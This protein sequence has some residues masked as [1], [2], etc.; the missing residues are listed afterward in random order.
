MKE[1]IIDHPLRNIRLRYNTEVPKS[2]AELQVLHD[3]VALHDQVWRQQ[4]W[5]KSFKKGLYKIAMRQQYQAYQVNRLFKDLAQIYQFL[6]QEIQLHQHECVL[7]LRCRLE[8]FLLELQAI[9]KE[10]NDLFDDISAR[11]KQ[12]EDFWKADL[13]FQHFFSEVIQHQLKHVY[14][15]QEVKLDL[16]VLDFDYREFLRCYQQLVSARDQGH[17]LLNEALRQYEKGIRRIQVVERFGQELHLTQHVFANILK[18]PN[19]N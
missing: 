13:E 18:R 4:Q 11:N 17:S 12:Y 19:L 3:Y 7:G 5:L 15:N 10:Y 9:R 8:K 1:I 6:R 2:G 14:G 16:E